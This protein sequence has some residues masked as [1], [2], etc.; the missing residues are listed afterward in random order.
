MVGGGY[1]KGDFSR[2][3]YKRIGEYSISLFGIKVGRNE[4]KIGN[5]DRFERVCQMFSS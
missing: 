2:E 1:N 5:R 3:W 4:T